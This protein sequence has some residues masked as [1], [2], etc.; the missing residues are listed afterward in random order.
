VS[1]HR[2]DSEHIYFPLSRS[3]FFKPRAS[4]ATRGPPNTNYCTIKC[5][6]LLDPA[7]L[8]PSE[9][10]RLVSVENEPRFSLRQIEHHFSEIRVGPGKPRASVR[11]RIVDIDAL[12]DEPQARGAGHEGGQVGLDFGIRVGAEDCG[13]E[14][15]GPG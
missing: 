11:G 14:G 4:N 3:S 13:D 5:K 10:I 9:D 2:S 6:I 15:H 12:V 7:L 8:L 1:E